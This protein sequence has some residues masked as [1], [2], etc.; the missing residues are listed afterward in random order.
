MHMFVLIYQKTDSR[1]FNNLPALAST[2]LYEITTC[3][4]RRTMIL[5]AKLNSKYDYFQ[6]VLKQKF[7]EARHT[8]TRGTLFPSGPGTGM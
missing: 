7:I 2:F 5:R 1:C 3:L 8:L 6:T 4:I